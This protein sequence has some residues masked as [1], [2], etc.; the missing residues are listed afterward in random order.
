MN[1]WPNVPI[2]T[3]GRVFDGPHATP[4]TTE[5]GP[6]FLGIPS[7][8]AGRLDLALSRHVSEADYSKWTRRVEPRGADFVFS[9][10]TKIGQAALVP[11]G[12]RCC[13]GR[14]MGLV[15]L[16][17]E[18]CDPRYF[19][20]QYLSPA[21]QQFLAS[22]TVH[23]ATVDRLLL[24]DF[25]D[26]P[27]P[28]P[29]LPEQRA[30]AATLGAL[31]DKIELNRRMGATLE[32]MVRA[33]YRSWFVDFDPVRA[34]MR[35]EAPAHMDPT[36]AALFPGRLGEDG[37]PEGWRMGCFGDLAANVR[38]QVAPGNESPDMPY[39]GLEH[40]PR[41]SMLLADWGSAS[42]VDSSKSRVRAGQIMFGK[43]RPYFHK[44]GIAPLDAI[45]STDILV[46]DGVPEQ[47]RSLAAAIAS[48]DEFIGHSDAASSGTRMP[49]AKWT[50]MATFEVP[51]API[52]VMEAFDRIVA[53]LHRKIIENIH[54]SRTL[55]ALR[56]AL[57]PRLMS[58]E[59]RISEREGQVAE[60]F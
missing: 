31:D 12:L 54:Q 3:I 42:Q 35:G 44:V 53:P 5:S 45:C 6:V 51:I 28:L 26:Y 8:N 11:D 59:L 10:E 39:F 43:L 32:G 24:T 18:R 60:F 30:I 14:R 56:D 37:L 36:T 15:R 47:S 40:L 34:K 49:R 19:L 23:G 13:L 21:Y 17:Q 29:T 57:L 33:L 25:P 9:Y 46:I 52:G 22:R 27:F 48:S 4:E 58:G 1:I 2:R 50:D 55:A 16:D 41:R 20:Y 7:L 38:E